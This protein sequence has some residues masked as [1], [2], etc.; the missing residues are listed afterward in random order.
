M[1]IT[2]EKYSMR[3][4]KI[5]SFTALIFLL[6]TIAELKAQ[7][8]L[9]CNDCGV[10]NY[11]VII[12]GNLYTGIPN[13]GIARVN[14]SD[15]RQIQLF[16]PFVSMRPDE[17]VMFRIQ[18]KFMYEI[19]STGAGGKEQSFFTLVRMPID[20]FQPNNLGEMKV[21]P[22]NSLQN[23]PDYLESKNQVI[24]E[25]LLKAS[26]DSAALRIPLYY[27]FTISTNERITLYISHGKGIQVWRHTNVENA[28]WSKEE[29]VDI[30]IDEAFIVIDQGGTE[31]TLMTES[32]EI[33]YL[34]GKSHNRL[35]QGMSKIK[36]L[37]DR[38]NGIPHFIENKD[39]GEHWI[40]TTKKGT[41]GT[42]GLSKSRSLKAG[43]I[44]DAPLPNNLAAALNNAL[45]AKAK[46]A[47]TK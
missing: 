29:V 42:I 39:S 26:T 7:Q 33:F 37:Q 44:D 36:N 13:E 31:S 15:Q 6:L 30:S 5:A 47:S 9:S 45:K 18:G 17:S 40:V 3:F 14:I 21:P 41:D 43:K 34:N 46:D 10:L 24:L 20:K 32:G 8:P 35:T 12:D 2:M 16:D 19:S 27:D 22:I 23:L 25:P 28:K 38:E 4:T 11:S 1:F